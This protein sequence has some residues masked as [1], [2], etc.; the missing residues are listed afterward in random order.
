MD[1]LQ[2][3]W[4]KNLIT[5]GSVIVAI[6]AW[7]AKLRWSKEYSDA[8]EAVISAKDEQVKTKQT[9]IEFLEK[10]IETLKEQTPE[11]LREYYKSVQKGLEEFNDQLQHELVEMKQNLKEKDTQLVGANERE[12]NLNKEIE[13]KENQI[14]EVRGK[15]AKVQALQASADLL[16]FSYMHEIQHLAFEDR[17]EK[18]ESVPYVDQE[19]RYTPR[20]IEPD[21]DDLVE[22]FLENYKDPVHGVPIDSGE[23]IYVLGGPY[24]ADEELFEQFPD[25]E[26]EIINAAVEKIESDG[27][28]NWVKQWQY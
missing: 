25:V 4:V 10:Q 18:Y 11:K 16:K 12:E 8:K 15:L 3:E 19:D 27:T 23:Y 14:Q 7:V 9:Q 24:H 20:P 5:L 22:W 26:E 28:I 1:W 17:Q 2:Q 13:L 21:V 6:L